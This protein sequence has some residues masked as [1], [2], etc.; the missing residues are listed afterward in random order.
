MR[1]LPE[2]QPRQRRYSVRQQ[3]RLDAETLAKL[4]VLANTFHRKRAAILHYAMPWGLAQTT[5]W[6]ID[7]SIPDRPL[8]VHMLVDH[9]LLQQEQDAAEAHGVTVAAWLRHAMRQVS[10]QD[11]PPSWRTVETV[12]RSHDSGSFRR[13]FGLRL[14]EGTSRKLEA[15]TQTFDRSAGEI[16]RQ[17]IVQSTPEDFPQSWQLAMEERRAREARSD[18]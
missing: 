14:D 18:A 4:E 8:L 7:P 6:S 12:A 1:L 3:A 5:V 2:P 15:L 9:Q 10:L 16:I 11:F 17:L 13:K